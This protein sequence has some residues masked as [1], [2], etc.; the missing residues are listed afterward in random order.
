MGQVCLLGVGHRM[1]SNLL[2][3]AFR[4]LSPSPSGSPRGPRPHAHEVLPCRLFLVLSSSL[5]RT[6][7]EVVVCRKP[8]TSAFPAS[9]STGS[10]MRQMS[11]NQLGLS[12]V[13]W[14]RKMHLVSINETGVTLFHA[15]AS[16][17]QLAEGWEVVP[18]VRDQ[19]PS[20]VLLPWSLSQHITS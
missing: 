20:V 1:E 14:D 8:R 4:R 19:A 11:V 13:K 5:D 16:W 15:E 12:L 2:G 6:F 7:L 17:R 10:W 18:G 9:S 3:R